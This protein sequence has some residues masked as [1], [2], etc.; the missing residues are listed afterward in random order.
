M[1][2]CCPV[3]RAALD[4]AHGQY[5]E[6]ARLRTADGS[7]VGTVFGYQGSPSWLF[8]VLSGRY[9]KGPYSEQIVTRSGMPVTLPPFRLVAASWGIATPVP[10]RDVALVRLIREP[11]GPTLEAALP[12][13]ER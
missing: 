8:Y 4:G 3:R 1:G 13:T 12:I 2:W 6:S 7:V 10:L 9:S 5:F 11:R